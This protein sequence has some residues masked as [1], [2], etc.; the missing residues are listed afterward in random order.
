MGGKKTTHKK[1]ENVFN[2]FMYFS[3]GSTAIRAQQETSVPRGNEEFLFP[4]EH[5]TDD[6]LFCFLTNQQNFTL[7]MK[8]EED[9]DIYCS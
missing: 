3:H 1:G 4:D 6:F 5:T 7:E 2:N 9:P 8:P